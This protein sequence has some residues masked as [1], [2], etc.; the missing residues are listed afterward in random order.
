[1]SENFVRGLWGFI[2]LGLGYSAWR[3]IKMLSDKDRTA[4]RQEVENEMQK[5]ENEV[6]SLDVLE[7]IKRANARRRGEHRSDKANPKK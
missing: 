3:F 4:F 5:S 7:L 2:L 6:H 1:V